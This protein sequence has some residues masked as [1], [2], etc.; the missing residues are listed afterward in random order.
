MKNRVDSNL[1]WYASYGSNLCEDRFL[2]YIKGG[3]PQGSK[4]M[5]SGCSDKTAPRAIQNI[6]I[7]RALYFAMEF[8]SWGK[9]G[10]AFIK[11]KPDEKEATLGRMYLITIEQFVDVVRQENDYEGKL[12]IDFY[13]VQEQGSSVFL[14]NTWYGN[15]IYLGEES[16]YPIFTFTNEQFLEEEINAPSNEYLN[17]LKVGVRESYKMTDIEVQSYFESKLGIRNNLDKSKG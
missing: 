2:C 14:S 16:G 7:N 4:K 10:V 9:G 3:M 13:N 11:N 6:I 5:H 17:T 15:L 8:S 12:E 1:V